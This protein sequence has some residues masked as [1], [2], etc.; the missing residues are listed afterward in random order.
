MKKTLLTLF[1]FLPLILI[2]QPVDLFQQ[3]N[4][5]L[6][7]TAFGNTLNEF[8]NNGPNANCD[9]LDSS[10]A[11]LSLTSGQTFVSAHLYWGSIGTGDFDV[12]LNG[13]AIS[14]ERTFSHTFNGNPYF[15]HLL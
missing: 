13:T 12:E 7:F 2:A 1:F 6:D 4:G 5:R 14:A 15:C 9:Q 3:F 11:S 10:T 8:P